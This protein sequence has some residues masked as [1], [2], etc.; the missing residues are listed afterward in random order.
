MKNKTPES[1]L[2]Q[3][4]LTSSIESGKVENCKLSNLDQLAG[5]ASTRRYFRAETDCGTYVVCLDHPWEGKKE[6]YT[7]YEV[8]NFLIENN[9]RVPAILDIDLKKGYLLEEDLGDQTFLK[10]M[11]EVKD[12]ETEFVEY[13]KCLDLMTSYH[14]IDHRALEKKFLRRKFDLDK[15]M[16]ELEFTIKHF[17]SGFLKISPTKHE[18]M[19]IRD[20]LGEICKEL[21]RK[22]MVITHRDFHSRNIMVKNNEFIL[23]DFQ[24]ARLGI[25]QYDMV[26]LL[27]DCYYQI[28]NKNLGKLKKYCFDNLSKHVDDQK[29]EEVFYYLYDLMLIQ[30]VFKAVGTFSYIYSVRGNHRYL[31]YIG[32]AMEKIKLA[33]MQRPHFS[34]LRKVLFKYYYEN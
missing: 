33:L 10:Y 11:S 7:F 13:K 20:T 29:T 17:Y 27:E 12:E 28:S 34:D 15:F 22:K 2:I 8:Q 30:R 14:N 24:D 16:E 9:V 6:D 4:L 31:K 25:P 3:T 19:I 5:D 23:I 26:S 18:K 1:V 32:F 21:A